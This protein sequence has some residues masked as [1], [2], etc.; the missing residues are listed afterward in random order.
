MFT[1]QL[2]NL[3]QPPASGTLQLLNALRGNQAETNRFLGERAILGFVD[4]VFEHREFLVELER[5]IAP[6]ILPGRVNSLAQVLLKLTAPGVP[7]V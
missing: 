2:A 6:L 1:A 4:K 5:F 7:D 3:A